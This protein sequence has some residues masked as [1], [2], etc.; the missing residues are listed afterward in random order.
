MSL[1]D[2]VKA[3]DY[4]DILYYELEGDKFN[5]IKKPGSIYVSCSKLRHQMYGLTPW[6]VDKN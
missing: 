5:A 4:A 6:N 3:L 2:L 1:T